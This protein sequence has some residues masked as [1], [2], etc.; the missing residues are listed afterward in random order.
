MASP[1]PLVI[2]GPSHPDLFGGVT[3]IMVEL[4]KP[5]HAYEVE[6]AYAVTERETRTVMVAAHDEEEAARI[7]V[8]RVETTACDNDRD[9]DAESIRVLTRPVTASEARAYLARQENV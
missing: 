7:A 9:H 2:A 1:E 5:L 3:P 4:G 6:V 8:E